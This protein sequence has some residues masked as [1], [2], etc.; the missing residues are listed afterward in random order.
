MRKPN[1][2]IAGVNKSGT[3]SLFSYLS[4]HPDI[5]AASIKETCYFLPVRYKEGDIPPIGMYLDYFKHCEGQ[6]YVM[7]S[8]PGYYYGGYELANAIKT[9]IGDVRIILIFRDP[10]DRCFSFYKSMKNLMK[11]AKDVSFEDYVLECEKIDPEDLK[12][13]KYN[14]YTGIMGGFYSDYLDGWFDVF[15]DSVKVIFFDDLRKNSTALLDDI[16]SWLAIDGDTL[17]SLKK[18]VENKSI[19][20]RS[21]G[22]HKTAL[23]MNKKAEKFFRRNVRFKSI[24]RRIYYSLNGLPP[25]ETIPPGLYDKL[26]T[27]FKPYNRK[28]ARKLL[29]RGCR[30]LPSWVSPGP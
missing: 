24:V 28:L 15:G 30:D 20:F 5:C 3:T 19:S 11:L 7:E 23:S 17:Y 18:G 16:C 9:H 4:Q 29:D 2:I 22:F 8:T 13:L 10:V 25:E 26:E 21:H 1:L 6:K 27:V 12:K 14:V